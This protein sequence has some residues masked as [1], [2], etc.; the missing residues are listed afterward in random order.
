MKP[1]PSLSFVLSL[2]AVAACDV[3]E[4]AAIATTHHT[5][6]VEVTGRERVSVAQLDV[7]R[8]GRSL[9]VEARL[10]HQQERETWHEYE[11]DETFHRS[12]VFL[13]ERAPKVHRRERIADPHRAGYSERYS[14]QDVP[15]AQL[16]TPAQEWVTTQIR[17]DMALRWSIRE[18]AERDVG[19]NSGVA[20][21]TDGRLAFRIPQEVLAVANLAP[22]SLTLVLELPTAQVG[23]SES[24][25]PLARALVR[26][27][28]AQ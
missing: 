16:Q 8:D 15:A 3:V 2:V 19:P 23:K 10:S 25:H 14:I 28:V 5:K 24:E 13:W 12:F 11:I 22:G 26:D 17:G 7:R 21:A 4:P 1:L 9:L 18:L 6:H 20:Q 27:A